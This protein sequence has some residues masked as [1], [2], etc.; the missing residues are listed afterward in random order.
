LKVLPFLLGISYMRRCSLLLWVVL[1]AILQAIPA[2]AQSPTNLTALQGLVPISALSNTAA[3][4]A[5]LAANLDI[6]AAVQDGSAKQPLLLPFPEQQ[7]QALRDAYITDGNAYELADGLGTGL[8]RAYWSLTTFQSSDDGKTSTFTNLSPAVALLISYTNRTTRSDSNSAKYFFGNGTTDGKTAV[9]LEAAAIMADAKGAPDIFGR[10]YDHPAGSSDADV[11]GDSRPFQTEP[12]LTLISGK[13]FFGI[14]SSNVDY[15]QGPKQNLRNSPSFPSGHTTYGYAESLILALLVP[16][17]YLEM[18]TRA[19]EYGN[20]RI[21][22]GAHYA[23]DVLG[24][25]TLATYD[26]AQLLANKAGYVGAKRG[27][28][29]IDKYQEAL[30]AARADVTAALEKECGKTLT[31]CSRQDDSRFSDP[32]KNKAFYGATQTYGLPVVYEQNA[33][34]TE[35]VGR[36][37]PE[38]GYLLT[39]AFPYLTL[40]QADDVLTKTEGPGGGFLDN[41]SAFGVYSRFDLYRAVEEA[42]SLAPKSE[43]HD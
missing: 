17:R 37:A 8:S 25:R 28:L 38:A 19:A 32:A 21:I 43:Q 24:G 5:A 40:A 3:G 7:Q 42:V 16:H 34:R 13:D 18:L 23:M 33:G 26:I 41:G 27:N 31:L 12:H 14:Q 39:A 1:I 22:L 2:L 30:A 36:L 10:V 6:T 4:K 15:L 35:D 29:V 11:Y 20:N 9:S